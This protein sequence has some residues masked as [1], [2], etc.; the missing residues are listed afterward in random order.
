MKVP[1]YEFMID[2]PPQWHSK[3]LR[4]RIWKKAPSLRKYYRGHISSLV[5]R[6]CC[7]H[8]AYVEDPGPDEFIVVDPDNCLKEELRTEFA[9]I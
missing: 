6:E 7:F 9:P 5:L 4:D 1:V 3:T 8:V 2:I